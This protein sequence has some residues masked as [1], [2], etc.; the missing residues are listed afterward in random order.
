MGREFGTRYLTSFQSVEYRRLWMATAC[1]QSASWAL[2]VARAALVLRLTDSPAWTGYVTFAAMIPSVLVSPVAGYLA[3][4][5]DRRA[6]LAWAYVVNL[7]DTM[8][9]ALLVA[10]R[11][12]EPWHVLLLASVTGCARSTQMPA[13]QAVARQHGAERTPPQR[14]F[15][16]P[17]DLSRRALY[18]AVSD[19]GG[20]LDYGASELGLLPMCWPLCFGLLHGVE[21]PNCFQGCRGSRQGSGY[22]DP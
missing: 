1:S 18:G 17:S 22:I 9:L 21:N 13:A 15:L 19:P 8:V 7:A 12:V 5:F 10:T 2:I 20:A 14:G 16:V 11:V 6:V 3:D 4:R